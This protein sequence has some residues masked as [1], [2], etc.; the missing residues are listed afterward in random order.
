MLSLEDSGHQLLDI[1]K[2]FL[3]RAKPGLDFRDW[4]S[5]SV[6]LKDASAAAVSAW[7]AAALAAIAR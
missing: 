4:I 5:A 7:A 1:F 3:D 6:V 2:Y